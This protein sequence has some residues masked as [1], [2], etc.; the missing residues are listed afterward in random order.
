MPV[1]PPAT[2]T[3]IFFALLLAGLL[4]MV[5][6]GVRAVVGLKKLNE[7]AAAQG[8]SSADLFIAAR[9]IV[10]LLIGF[11]AGTRLDW[12]SASERFSQLVLAT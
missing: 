3:S 2:P 10:S 4:G 12:R 9:L 11:I 5:G 1:A 6:Q 7:D 8:V